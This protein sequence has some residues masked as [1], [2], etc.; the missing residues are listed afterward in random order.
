MLLK[1]VLRS[2][3]L[4]L[5]NMPFTPVVG[6]KLVI[7]GEE[8]KYDV[9]PQP[10]LVEKVVHKPVLNINIIGGHVPKALRQHL[11]IKEASTPRDEVVQAQNTK[12][13]SK[14]KTSQ[15][16]MDLLTSKES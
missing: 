10:H 3:T 13:A 16:K 14:I 6:S 1:W 15:Y 8:R 12:Q 11:G 5:N 4:N 7:S 9:A 2:N